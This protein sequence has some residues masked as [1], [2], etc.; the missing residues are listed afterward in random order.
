MGNIV[1]EKFEAYVLKQIIS[2]QSMAGSSYLEG[3]PSRSNEQ[4]QLLNNKNAWL[5]MASS[6]SV[7]SQTPEELKEK[8]T[9]KAEKVEGKW[10]DS[11]V[12]SG[13]K[14][15][16]DIG[17]SD[18]SNFT[19]TKLAEKTVL[20]NTLSQINPANSSYTFRSGVS[21]SNQLWNNSSYGLGGTN[22]GLVPAPGLLSFKMDSLNRGSIKKGTIE[23]KCYN[24]FQFELIEL[25]Y[26]RLGFT[27]M[28]EWGWDKYTTDGE[29]LLTVGNTL[30]E[31]QWFKGSSENN[32]TQLSML[33]Q[34][35]KYRALYQG[36]YDGFYGKVSNFSWK[37]SPD[38]SYDISIDLVSLGDV[39]ESIKVGAITTP[40]TLK[41]I[42]SDVKNT[43][44]LGRISDST[45]VTNAN[46]TALAQDLYSDIINR[47]WKEKNSNYIKPTAIGGAGFRDNL[48]Y[49]DNSSD[50]Y[51]YYMT[52][53]A[54]M[55]KLKDLTIPRVLNEGGI[56]MDLIQFDY[57][58]GESEAICAAY[59]NQISLDPRVCIIKPDLIGIGSNK[60][61]SFI[62]KNTLTRWDYFK[63]FH[64]TVKGANGEEVTYGKI[65]DIY[66][67]YD[68]V[69]NKLESATE[70]MGDKKENVLSLYKFVQSICDGINSALGGINNLEVAVKNDNVLVILEQN[71]IPGIEQIKGFEDRFQEPPSFE[72]FGFNPENGGSNFVKDFDFDTKITPELASLVTIGATANGGTTKNYDATAFSSWNTGLYDRFNKEF[73]DPADKIEAALKASEAALKE[74]DD[75]GLQGVEGEI[76]KQQALVLYKAYLAA[77]IDNTW[78]GEIKDAWVLKYGLWLGAKFS[79]Q[80]TSTSLGVEVMGVKTVGYNTV[81]P[82]TVVAVTW[83]EY[84]KSTLEL[85]KSAKIAGDKPLDKDGMLAKYA[86]SYLFYLTRIFGGRFVGASYIKEEAETLEGEL[87]Y[88]D[89]NDQIIKEGKAAFKAYINSLH[90]LILAKSEGKKGSN[91]L[92]FLPISM[93]ITFEGLSGIKIYN[94]INIGQRFLPSNYPSSFKFIISTVNHSISE[95]GWETGIDTISTPRT[96]ST[97]GYSFADL[98]GVSDDAQKI[99][100]QAYEL[101]ENTKATPIADILRIFIAQQDR[102]TEKLIG[103]DGKGGYTKGITGGELSSGGDISVETLN[104]GLS[105]FENILKLTDVDI[106]ITAGNDLLHNNIKKSYVSR[107]QGPGKAGELNDGGKALDFTISPSTPENL[108]KVNDILQRYIMGNKPWWYLDEYGDPSSISSGGH[109]HIS[110]ATMEGAGTEE[111]KLALKYLRNPELN[112]PT[113]GQP[114]M[115]K[116]GGF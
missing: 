99:A 8:T 79:F 24:K 95:N 48:K 87:T 100:L 80:K 88:F 110:H 55:G 1:G 29:N 52:L 45:I 59:P 111:R 39:I 37:F 31:E 66:L 78:L 47:D 104:M 86:E 54:L 108:E 102:L 11:S 51:G 69:S 74:A 58:S 9:S 103:K 96:F 75:L 83:E 98:E 91:V 73:I 61:G 114:Y 76:T 68:F 81:N 85:I 28:V 62:N 107:H 49:S 25:V 65:Y 36:N 13:E 57:P 94:Q 93:A 70:N 89:Y 43:T 40:L 10:E 77:K 112:L 35:E 6:V 17:I 32:L 22:Q 46:S 116:S 60:K 38:G 67:N 92:G 115:N 2:R 18:T 97:R 84:V 26:L 5:K 15:L 4:L 27:M 23:L 14:R 72:I 82:N 33:R 7:V 12:S 71:P 106:V 113:P 21:D 50:K 42:K 16:N 109:F 56:A 101:D 44:S 34:I 64:K 41:Q 63:P 53:G 3:L 105:I 19:G 30:I 20:F 90:N